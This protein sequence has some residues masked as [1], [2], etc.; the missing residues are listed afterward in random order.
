MESTDVEINFKFQT[1]P[2]QQTPYARI[3]YQPSKYYRMRYE[4]ENRKSFVY[5]NENE[6]IL[7]DPSR[8]PDSIDG[9]FPQIEVFCF[10]FA[11]SNIKEIL[12]LDS[13]WLKLVNCQG[14]ATLIVSCVNKENP[15]HVNPHKLT[16]DYCSCG[17]ACIKIKHRE[18]IFK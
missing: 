7:N 14:P 4:A 5:S 18:T 16:G 11:F 3:L 8:D 12:K 1:L 17:V 10:F 9:V 6:T 13:S 15:Y 2:E